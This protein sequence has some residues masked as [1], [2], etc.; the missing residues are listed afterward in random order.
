[1][2]VLVADT[3]G[4][5]SL[6]VAA[7]HDPDPLALCLD[8]YEVLIPEAVVEE[9]E[10]MPSHD[11]AHGRAAGTVLAQGVDLT[12][13][14]ITSDEELPLDDGENAAGSLVREN[15]VEAAVYLCDGVNHLGLIHA[16]L[17]S[18]RLVTTPPLP[19]VFLRR[20]IL[21]REEGSRSST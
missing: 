5:V 9:I 15:D 10:E 13:E 19:A 21:S 12:V 4:L 18:S 7:G 20:D 6:A 11:D 3:S 2:S 17:A 16:S 14:P 8:T 1:M